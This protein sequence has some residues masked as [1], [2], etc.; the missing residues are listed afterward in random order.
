MCACHMLSTVLTHTLQVRISLAAY[1]K[2]IGLNK[3]MTRLELN[4]NNAESFCTHVD[5]IR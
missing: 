3:T 5:E 1:F 4:F 2:R